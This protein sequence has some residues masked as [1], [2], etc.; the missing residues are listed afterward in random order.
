MTKSIFIKNNVKYSF[1]ITLVNYTDLHMV[2]MRFNIGWVWGVGLRSSAF[3]LIFY[4]VLQPATTWFYQ[5]IKAEAL[6]LHKAD[7]FDGKPSS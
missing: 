3:R 2:A 6:V 7:N 4:G 5:K 1:L